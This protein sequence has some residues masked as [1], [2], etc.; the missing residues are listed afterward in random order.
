M[1]QCTRGVCGGGGGVQVVKLW[2]ILIA[3]PTL[4]MY[5]SYAAGK[6]CVRDE[7]GNK[8]MLGGVRVHRAKK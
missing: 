8:S 5:A 6:C 7:Y 3:S 1:R 2:D 4:H